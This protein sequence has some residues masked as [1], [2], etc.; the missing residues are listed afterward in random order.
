MQ[1]QSVSMYVDFSDRAL[2][3]HGRKRHGH[4]WR[5]S[6]LKTILFEA[7]PSVIMYLLINKYEN[8]MTYTD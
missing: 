6:A 1:L 3:P 5:Y 7:S 2:T 8:I 4:L